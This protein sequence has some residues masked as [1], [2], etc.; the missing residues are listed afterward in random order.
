MHLSRHPHNPVLTPDAS[1][2]E[3]AIYNPGVFRV[4]RTVFLVPRVRSLETRESTFTL[5][6][7]RDG[8]TFER[9]P[10]PIMRG[11]APYE[12]PIPDRERESGGVEDCR[13]TVHDGR[14]HL[15]YT[16]YNERCHLA[17]A[18][19]DLERFLALWRECRGS[20]RDR[21][22]DWDRAWIRCGPVFPRMLSEEGRFTRNGSLFVHRGRWYLWFR[23]DY[24]PIRLATASTAT[25]PWEITPLSIDADL[26]WENDRI[27]ISSP[28]IALDRDRYLF[29][30]HGVA[31]GPPSPALQHQ[32]TYHLGMLTV[33]FGRAS[34]RIERIVK[35]PD[36]ILSPATDHELAPGPWLYDDQLK[37]A[38]VFACGA[39]VHRSKLLVPYGAGDHHI[40]VGTMDMG[41]VN[42]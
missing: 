36:P 23:Q 11:T 41:S 14:I 30:Y 8:S 21:S 5:A 27:G 24:G 31:E 16:A 38:A 33:E 34:G 35:L 10:F 42:V 20:S 40:C 18:W 9:L 15:V 12:A 19:M 13:V 6:W 26:P 39:V 2:G 17:V 32:R 22:S 4:E 3:A 7:T 1:L 29:L 28:A 25:G 37:V